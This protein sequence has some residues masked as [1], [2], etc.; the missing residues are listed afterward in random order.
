MYIYIS[1]PAYTGWKLVHGDVFRPPF[2]SPMIFRYVRVHTHIHKYS[3]R[4]IHTVFCI[5]YSCIL[6][7][8]ILQ[9]S[10]YHIHCIYMFVNHIHVYLYSVLVGSG[11]Q[12]ICMTVA[13]LTFALFGLLS[14]DNRGSIVTA[15]ILLFVF[16]GAFA[17]YYSALTYKMFR[18]TEW[19]Y[20]TILTA[21]LYP[22]GVSCIILVLNTALW[23]QGSTGALPFGTFF[24]LLF[25]W[26]CV[27]VPLVSGGQNYDLDVC[28]IYI[29][30]YVLMLNLYILLYLMP[31][32]IYNVYV[33]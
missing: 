31:Y 11:A 4:L 2:T 19:K 15:F 29:C 6:Y 32:T 9:Y 30:I 18:G 5:S 25:L 1:T 22:G 21:L 26:F 17:G 27:S 8:H 20:N 14:P 23:V 13:L 12:L 33:Y 16:M 7:A 10:V 24:T 28:G 3:I